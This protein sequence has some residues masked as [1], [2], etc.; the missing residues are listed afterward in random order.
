MKIKKKTQVTNPTFNDVRSWYEKHLHPDS[1]SY[2]DPDVYKYVYQDG[3]FA[4]V[5]QLTSAGAQRFFLKARPQTIVDIAVLTSIY[6]P[7][8]LAANV[9][10]LYID[11]KQNGK[12]MDWGHPLFEKVLGETY[13]CLIFQES[14]MD[15]AEHV[16]GFP[17]DQCDNVRRAIMKRDQ[18]KGDASIKEA[19]SMEE[20][21]VKGA[22][23]KGVKEST[24]QEAYKNILYF[25]GYGFN[26]AHAV[27]YAIDSYMCAWLHKHYE[28]EWLC[29]YL[30]SMSNNPEDRARAFGEIKGLG[31][32]ISPIDINEAQMTWTILPGRRFMPSISSCKGVGD[33]AF[34]EIIENR[35]YDSIEDLLWNDAGEW[36]HSKLN[37]RAL[38]ALIKTKS[39]A[40]LGC[41]GE[42]KLFNSW[43][44]M[45][46]VIV[47][48]MDLIKKTSKRDP[49]VGKKNFYELIKTLAP[50]VTEWTKQ[51]F[52]EFSVEYFG[53]IDVS[54]LLSQSLHDK[55][56]DKDVKP[57]DQFEN[58]DTDI[59]W[60]VVQ[61]TSP[62]V[63]K[64]K[65]KY[66]EIEALGPVGKPVRLRAW[67][68]DGVKV[69]QPLSVY[70]GEIKKD[71][72]GCS[73]TMWKIKEIA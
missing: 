37:K 5:F 60:F 58:G 1:N 11:A 43:H 10:K 40:S 73:T 39:L 67:G 64:N 25:A 12:T 47:E 57:I 9:D 44:L 55:L 70:L 53:S 19:K 13:N 26:K 72:F 24:A 28:S 4:G 27:A 29:A 17:K 48:N 7:G 36:R 20:A 35:P 50:I 41:V 23:A 32:K 59:G 30:E 52:A 68:W 49:D 38:E 22:A 46:E 65:K 33:A 34:Q 71:D 54:S 15:L 18:S 66:L 69:L 45:H 2:D 3:N 8:P 6:R 31:Y 62:K 14:V 42:G 16:G 63:T 21:F 51:E 56:Y 61:K